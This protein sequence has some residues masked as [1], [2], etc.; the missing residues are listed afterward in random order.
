MD[1]ALLIASMV[2]AGVFL[3]TSLS[4]LADRPGSRQALMDLG[5]PT[6]LGNLLLPLAKLAVA[7]T[8]IPSGRS[9]RGLA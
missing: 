3:V 1:T 2:L 9:A 6:P 8:L 7:S 5:V 4:K